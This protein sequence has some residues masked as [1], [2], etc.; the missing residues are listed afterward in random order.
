MTHFRIRDA[1]LPEDKPAMLRF[2]M[3]LQRVEK[4]IEPD[5]RIDEP[6]AEEF[7]DIVLRRLAERNGRIF[8]AEASGHSV[9]WAQAHEEN[10][11]IYVVPEERRYGHIAELYVVE[12]ARGC[13]IGRA[14]IA[15]C[16]N[17]ARERALRTVT[18]GAL[19]G[20]AR[21]YGLYQAAGYAPY[22]IEL[23]KYLR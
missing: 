21:A 5:R 22:V 23:R 7:Y 18:I 13:G 11:E 20:N 10:N 8:I 14:L 1:R 19:S 6:V 17:W 16:E 4:E 3:A 15:A 9:G 2:I 12:E